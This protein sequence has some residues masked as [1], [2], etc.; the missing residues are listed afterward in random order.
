[1]AEGCALDDLPP[2]VRETWL[3]VQAIKHGSTIRSM[4]R[5]QA[6]DASS[7]VVRLADARTKL[8]GDDA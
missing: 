5:D 4:L 7:N 2:D 1:M 8:P 3:D 6:I